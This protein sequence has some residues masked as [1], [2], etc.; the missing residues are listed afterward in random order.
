[1]SKLV[2]LK[3]LAYQKSEVLLPK[4]F[5]FALQLLPTFETELHEGRREDYM[6]KMPTI[7]AF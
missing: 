7:T 6:M 1:M 3:L 2:I 4:R 5:F